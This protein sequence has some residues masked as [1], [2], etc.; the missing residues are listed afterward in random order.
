[1]QKDYSPSTTIAVV[2]TKPHGPE[3]MVEGEVQVTII[4]IILI[5]GVALGST[6]YRASENQVR[7]SS[8]KLVNSEE[9]Q[10][11]FNFHIQFRSDGSVPVV[12]IL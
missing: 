2:T 11:S 9:I 1:M 8:T 6:G 3:V 12:C 7:P 10:K 5:I 4:I